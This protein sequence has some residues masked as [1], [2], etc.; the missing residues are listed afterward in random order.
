MRFVVIY[1]VLAVG[2]GA[3]LMLVSPLKAYL[4][5]F[6]DAVETRGM[7]TTTTC[8]D[9][10]TFRYRYDVDGVIF[11]GSGQSGYR[12]DAQISSRETPWWCSIRAAIPGSAS[13]GIC[14]TTS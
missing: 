3:A 12:S 2:I 5:R 6:Q 1:V 10:A 4:R 13:A 7:V 8:D 14:V 9:H 11:D